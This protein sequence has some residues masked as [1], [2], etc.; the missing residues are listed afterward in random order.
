MNQFMN[1]FRRY[2][3]MAML[4]ALACTTLSTAAET[5]AK[6]R[7][8]ATIKEE[9]ELFRDAIE[10]AQ[11]C[12]TRKPCPRKEKRAVFRAAK[13]GFAIIAIMATLGTLAY[14]AVPKKTAPTFDHNFDALRTSIE[15]QNDSN[16]RILLRSTDFKPQDL[17]GLLVVATH[18]GTDV[19]VQKL[20][21]MTLPKLGKATFIDRKNTSL[22]HHVAVRASR[23]TDNEYERQDRSKIIDLL[24]RRGAPIDHQS[25]DYQATALMQ[26]AQTHNQALVEKLLYAGA[27]KVLKDKEG[28]TAYDYAKNTKAPAEILELLRLSE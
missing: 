7:A 4:F 21:N 8:I 16:L 10:G 28:Q 19:A 9:I 24:I 23:K 11:K 3:C 14:K 5:N 2:Y 25:G 18:F 6:Q 13:H 26:A 12:I 22:L 1:K 15:K 17:K 27:K 20:L